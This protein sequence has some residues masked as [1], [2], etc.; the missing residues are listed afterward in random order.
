MLIKG[1]LNSNKTDILVNE[2]EKLLNKGVAAEDIL[3]IVQNFKKKNEFIEKTKKLLTREAL[4]SFNVYTFFGLVYNFILDNWVIVENKIKDENA[5]IAPNLSGLEVSQYI[6][7]KA[8]DE[9]QFKGYNSKGNLLHQLLRRYS[10]CVLNALTPDEIKER[11][12]IL[13]DP[14]YSDIKNALNLYKLKTLNLRAFDYLRQ[15]DIFKYI[16]ENTF[17]PYKYVFLDDGDE[18]TPAL[19][20]YLKFIKPDI[21]E[22]FIAYDEFGCTR[23]GFLGALEFDFERFLDESPKLAPAKTLKTKKGDEIFHTIK[24]G[25]SVLIENSYLQSFIRQDEMIAEAVR[26]INTLLS[27]PKNRLKPSDIAIV[28]PNIDDY[29][30]FQ[31]EKINAPVQYLSGS[32]KLSKNPDIAAILEVLKALNNKNLKISPYVFRGILAKILKLDFNLVLKI[33]D[34]YEVFDNDIFDCLKKFSENEGVARFLEICDE[35]TDKKLSIQ[36]YTV[37]YEYVELKPENK[38]LLYKINQLLKQVR[39][40]EEIFNPGAFGGGSDSENALSLSLNSVSNREL[41]LQL[42][43]TIVS[44]NPLSSA[45]VDEN[46]VVVST[47]QKLIDN[48]VVSKHTFLLD[49]TSS[50]WTKQDIGPLYNAWV[51]QK[52]WKKKSFELEDNI[53]CALDKTSRLIRKIYLLNEGEIYIYSSI[54]D[55]LGAENFKGINHFFK[56][57]PSAA[58]NGVMGEAQG[59]SGNEAEGGAKNPAM[60]PKKGFKIVPRPDQAP[61]LEYKEGK[62]AVS[63]VAGAGKTT[64][65]LALILKLLNENV[66]PENIFVLTFMESAAR[67]F[68]ERI[69]EAFPHLVELPHISTIHGLAL[70]ILRENNNH[71]KL[72]LD[73]D[74]EILDEIKRGQIIKDIISALGLDLLKAELY[75]RAISAY[76]NQ[77][78]P[79]PDRLSPLF[80]RIFETYKTTLLSSNFIDYDDLLALS[81]TLLR[82]DKGIREYY[83]NLMKFVIEDEAQD[84][85][86]IQ[87]ELIKILSSKNGNLIRCGDVNQAITTTFSNADVKGFKR[88]ISENLNV[89]MDYSNRNATGIIDFSNKLIKYGEKL[90]PGAFLPIQAK[91]VEG[92]NIVDKNSVEEY[93]FEKEG[94]EKRFIL[95]KIGSIY[96]EKNTENPSVAILL[97]SNRGVLEWS[98]FLSENSTFDFTTNSDTLNLNPVFRAVLAVLNFINNP[99][100]NNVVKNCAKTLIE[101]GF[102]RDDIEILNFLDTLNLPFILGNNEYFSLFWDLKYFV[103]MWNLPIY[104]I[105]Y[106]IGEFYFGA[107]E[108]QALAGVLGQDK[109]QNPD[110]ENSQGSLRDFQKANIS[111]VSG[112]V[113]KVFNSNK[114]FEDTVK[115]LNDMA[116]KA[117]RTGI[118]L[119]SDAENVDS[120]LNSAIRILTL[121]K[122]KGDEFNYVFI[123]E[124][125]TDNL[126]FDINDIKLKENSKFIESVKTEPKSEEELKKEIQ[127]ENLR[128][129]YVGFTRAKR[130]LYL[131]CAREYKIYNKVREKLP[132][133]VFEINSFLEK[134]EFRG[135]GQDITLQNVAEEG[136]EA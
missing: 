36:L 11:A 37:A 113:S 132:N 6:F 25:D 73:V 93:I 18:I 97:R 62:M 107:G 60:A 24:A 82:N 46:A 87:Q 109:E 52:S 77:K 63:A 119:V 80:R 33:A 100:N 19:F 125:F 110:K 15:T 86:E 122:S 111:L 89:K 27:D 41:I 55:F 42:E 103:R 124:M 116:Q 48:S 20:E 92:K 1:H 14:F 22:F 90:A 72:N 61:V 121:H 10:L 44:E 5:K 74:F 130:K 50:N 4:T 2:Y 66:P 8:I 49:T 99:L 81:L 101:L 69:K 98:N 32:E 117:N 91:P 39:D 105:A 38:S 126:T 108:K 23:K 57:N 30:K 9:V 135:L 67:N 51:F 114:T 131:T 34:D 94:D 75:E 26:K 123:P 106:K 79:Q 115:K 134:L 84:S 129:A 136:E 54:Y 128:L 133:Q 68:K 96:N 64:I 13:S 71:T 53:N 59:G 35:M 43:N 65:M 47:A 40:F 83:Q 104:E 21:K 12:K 56:E 7:R 95:D 29:L 28:T 120:G 70:R 112:I 45:N 118:K 3:V 76:K 127:E 78:H 102:Y 85:S 58:I 88:F 16:Y 17:N 31:L